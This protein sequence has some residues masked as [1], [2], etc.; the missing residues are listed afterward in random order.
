MKFTIKA[1]LFYTV[2]LFIAYVVCGIANAAIFA[3]TNYYGLNDFRFAAVLFWVGLALMETGC[4]VYAVS[5]ISEDVLFKIEETT[6]EAPGIENN[7]EV[8]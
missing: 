7:K 2:S 5:A 8:T 4:C 1:I 6:S 3:L